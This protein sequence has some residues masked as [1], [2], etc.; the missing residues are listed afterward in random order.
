[1]QLEQMPGLKEKIMKAGTQLTTLPTF[2][3]A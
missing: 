1:M 2:P 3:V